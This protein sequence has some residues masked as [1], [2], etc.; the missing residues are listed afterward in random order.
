VRI[1]VDVSP[2]ALPRT[3]IGNYIRGSLAGLAEAAGEEHEIV[4]FAPTGPRGLRVI[5]E[6]LAGIPV[7][8]KLVFLPLARAWR[9]AW[10]RLGRP[11]VERVVGRLD[12]F[13]FSDWMYPTQSGGV[14]S[15]T[16]HDLIP[17]R[18]PDAVHPRTRALHLPKYD[19]AARTCDLLFVN[20]RFTAGEV[21]E[22]LGVSEERVRVAPPGVD[23]VF[24]PDGDRADLGGPYLLAIQAPDPRKNIETL[25]A[26]HRLLHEA[27]RLELVGAGGLGY[28][29]DAELARRYRGAS[30]FVYPSRFEGFGMPIVE[31]MAC[32]TPV[33]ASAHASLDEACGDAAL[34]ADPDSPEE[35]AAAIERAQAER[36]ELV[37]RGLDHARGFT[38]AR[39]GRIQLDALVAAA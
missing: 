27:P 5:P 18:F 4:A 25:V 36:G 2:L 34:R 32:G 14:R 13:H 37:R 1:V 39:A 19:N 16:I 15:T 8:R 20:S 23:A 7:Q 30:V 28:L 24:R 22:L 29:S 6:A 3:G 11:S 10:S 38:W 21:V 12:A 9:T 31:A 35:F 17:L 26:A 33:V